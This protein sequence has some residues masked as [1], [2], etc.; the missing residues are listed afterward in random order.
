MGS[1]KLSVDACCMSALSFAI[2]FSEEAKVASESTKAG[3]MAARFRLPLFLH[4]RWWRKTHSEMTMTTIRKTRT[5]LATP[6]QRPVRK[7]KH[8][9]FKIV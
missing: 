2:N 8:V 6:N 9:K 1:S 7:T 3:L 4:E 5:A